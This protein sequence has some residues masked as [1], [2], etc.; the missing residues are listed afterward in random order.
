MRTSILALALL[1]TFGVL[2]A[3]QTVTFETADGITVTADNYVVGVDY[4]YILLLHQAGYSRGEYRNIAPKLTNMGYNCLA[5]DQRSGN[6]VNGV[7]NATAQLAK[8]KNLPTN[9][10]DALPDILAAIAYIKTQ[11]SKPIIIW[12]SSYSASLAL[13]AANSELRIGG[14]VVFSPGE[15]FE[16][17][18]YVR[19]NSSKISVPVFATS[20]KSECDETKLTCSSIKPDLLTFFCPSQEGVH[21][22]SALNKSNPSNDD[23]W[24]A[25]SMFFSKLE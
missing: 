6:E 24:L 7:K 10:I 21:G 5:I 18:E 11:N 13:V 20:A 4:P 14:V 2:N 23:Y 19:S 16:N 8:S 9:Y 22:S 3:Q 25:L 12:G 1:M 17:K 15:Y